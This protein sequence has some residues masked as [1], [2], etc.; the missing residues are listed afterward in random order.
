MGNTIYPKAKTDMWLLYEQETGIFREE[1]KDV[2][3]R[4]IIDEYVD[5]VAALR[6][7][8]ADLIKTDADNEIWKERDKVASSLSYALSMSRTKK[9]HLTALF[10][11]VRDSR[12]EELFNMNK[13][14][15]HFENGIVF[16]MH[17]GEARKASEN[18]YSTMSTKLQ[19]LE[20]DLHPQAKKDLL[21]KFFDDLM[22]GREDLI[23]YLL[24]VLSSLLTG[25]TNDQQFY[26][27]SGKGSNGK[28]TL[29]KLLK[30]MLGHYGAPISSAQVARPNLNAQSATPS[31]AALLYKRAAF[32]TEM[33]EKTL[34]TEFLKMVAGGDSTS[35][36]FLQSAQRDIELWCKILIA[37]NDLPG[38][39]DK[40][41]GFWRKVVVIP[42]DAKFTVDPDPAKTNEIKTNPGFE[43]KLMEC[44]DTLAAWLIKIYHTEYLKTGVQRNAQPQIVLDKVREYQESQ[45]IPLQFFNWNI[46]ATKDAADI[47][48]TKQIDTAFATFCKDKAYLKTPQLVR[49]VYEFL[50]EKLPPSN[51]RRQVWHNGKNV[52][53]WSGCQL[54]VE[55]D[56]ETNEDKSDEDVDVD[57][58]RSARAAM[59]S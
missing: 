37:T 38:I 9:D 4:P 3:T 14:L 31:L 1:F 55:E 44:A 48:T 54:V 13:H 30:K 43:A 24:K 56:M 57:A 15:L 7:I 25:E 50:D 2:I 12:K 17:L 45:N 42:C 26:F 16:D 40:T 5:Q 41:H 33:E 59:F 36:R 27:F 39:V 29:V 28:S 8:L 21:I 35:G 46:Q 22:L 51:P 58:V 11:L 20:Y 52:R 10:K 53:A 34:Y 6:K 47:I 19:Y 23:Q 49:H 18:D 32:L